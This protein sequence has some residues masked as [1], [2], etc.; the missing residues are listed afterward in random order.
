MNVRE[1][2]PILDL[3]VNGKKLVY[4][5][6]AATTQRPLSVIEAVR[7]Y[8]L[9]QNGNPH[10]GSHYLSIK[11]TEVYEG[12]REKVKSFI[13]AKSSD[14]VIFTRNTTESINLVAYS[15]GMENLKAG[16]KIIITIAEHHSNLVPWQQVAKVTGS[17]LHYMYVDKEGRLPSSELDKIDADTKIVACTHM[18]NVLGTIMPVKAIIDR[19]HSVGAVAVIDGAQSV[20]HMKVSV[21]E[22]D[23]D[24][25]AF[26][27]HK[28]LSQLGI[29]VLYG[30]K[31]LLKSMKPF[32]FG[33]DM[34]E[35]VHEQETS[36][37]ELPYKFEAGT[38]N[39]EG[40]AS[41]SAAIDYIN[42]LGFDKIAEQEMLLTEHAL[43][44]MKKLPYI[45]IV[46]PRD[47]SERGAVISFTVEGVHPHDV[48]TILDSYGI[49]VRAGHH[50]A[51][52]LMRYLGIQASN[53][54]S[55]CFYNTI[56]E[57]DYF[58]GKLGEIRRWMGYGA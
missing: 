18:S 28:L 13:G 27:G 33:G 24:F 57:V 39:V 41:L 2:F 53:R 48:A 42:G 5:D 35:Y 51:Q 7:K 3:T 38:Q 29:G 43:E 11:A 21:T 12:T 31:E 37:N 25:F 15:Y 8:D 47:L 6:N 56:D 1:D 45:N 46:G 44:G 52:P 58:L 4:F 23:A 26:S 55:F 40:A 14:E 36:F 50:C 49:A 32:L 16:D 10:R 20:P 17:T 9:E 54:A 30:K 19:A 22:L 34:I